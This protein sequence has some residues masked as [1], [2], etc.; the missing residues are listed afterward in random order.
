MKRIVFAFTALVLALPCQ[1]IHA[2]DL[3]EIM[4][5][6]TNPAKKAAFKPLYEF[7]AYFRMEM[8]GSGEQVIYDTY[9]TKGGGNLAMVFRV[10]GT[11]TT[12][13]IDTEN[14]AMVM[15]VESG[16]EKTGF[17]MAVNPDAIANLAS[18]SFDDK[19]ADEFRTGK[20]KSI[21]GYTCQEYLIRD[22]NSVISVW[23]SEK[24]GREIGQETL[25]NQKVFGGAFGHAVFM[26]GM[27]MEYHYENGAEK[28]T[29]KVTDIDLNRKHTISTGEYHVMSFGQTP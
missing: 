15:L 23:S 14:E 27:V 1:Y 20:T 18:D 13:I 12:F 7:D 8:T 28:M 21:L 2:Q 26:G 16:G 10:E 4:G 25:K 17:A 19:P 11:P 5:Q 22:G 24:L 3:Q 9:L 29:L 6:L